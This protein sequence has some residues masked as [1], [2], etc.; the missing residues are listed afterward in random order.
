MPSTDLQLMYC[1]TRIEDIANL[2]T[3]I[4]IDDIPIKDKLRF[5]KGDGPA[6]QFEAGQQK[7]G[8]YKCWGCSVHKNNSYDYAAARYRNLMSFEERRD[9][10][11]ET[12]RSRKK[13]KV[14]QETK[15]FTKLDRPDLILELHQR[16][17]NKFNAS[18]RTK[19]LQLFLDQTMHGI[20]RVPAFL[21]NSP[22]KKLEDVCLESYELL[23]CEPL[24][25][26]S[27]HIQN[28]FEEV[29]AHIEDPKKRNDFKSV[30][31]AC[32]QKVEM[33]IIEQVSS[34]LFNSVAP[35][36]QEPQS[37]RYFEHY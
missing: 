7:G 26:L 2:K 11:M 27:H 5:F 8:N 6:A 4:C 33:L 20:Q 9:K 21:F 14:N 12:E 15:L 19:D 30:K 32:F 37:L 34:S 24:H 18:T 23:L 35:K 3:E 10:V 25:D 36:C 31:N 22:D 1:D 29:P 13:A 17:K 28:L 16:S